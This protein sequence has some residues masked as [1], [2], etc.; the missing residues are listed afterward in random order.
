MDIEAEAPLEVQQGEQLQVPPELRPLELPEQVCLRAVSARVNSS[1][2][3]RFCELI[4]SDDFWERLE[5]AATDPE[6]EAAKRVQ[7]ELVPLLSIAGKC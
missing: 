3:E 4:G 2:F 6:G 5:A 7:R 1:S